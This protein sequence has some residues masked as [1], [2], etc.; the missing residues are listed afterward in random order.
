MLISRIG[1]RVHT[2][3]EAMRIKFLIGGFFTWY[4]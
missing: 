3:A 2:V 4:P 1:S